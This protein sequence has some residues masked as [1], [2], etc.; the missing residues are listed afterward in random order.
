MSNF[1]VIPWTVAIPAPHRLLCPWDFF[2][3][4]YW[5]GL[6]F[7]S[8]GHLPDPGIEL[9]SPALA[10]GFF[11]NE[12]WEASVSFNREHIFLHNHST[13][14]FLRMNRIF[15][16]EYHGTIVKFRKFTTETIVPIFPIIPIMFFKPFC[17]QIRSIIVFTITSF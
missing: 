1:F 13:N 16:E 9:R 5:S 17:F 3:Q 11:T 7:P 10:G 2:R 14:I 4:E 6:P 8:P 12:P 15:N